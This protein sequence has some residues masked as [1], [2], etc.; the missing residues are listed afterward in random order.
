MVRLSSV[1]CDDWE[2]MLWGE[3][4]S[5]VRVAVQTLFAVF[6]FSSLTVRGADSERHVYQSFIPVKPFQNKPSLSLKMRHGQDP[7][8][9][10]CEPWPTPSNLKFASFGKRVRVVLL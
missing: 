4:L 10:H 7:T 5:F 6:V 9:D 2:N 3:L 8:S 1:L